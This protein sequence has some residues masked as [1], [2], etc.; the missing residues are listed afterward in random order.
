MALNQTQDLAEQ[1]S[2]NN[3]T[4]PSLQSYVNHLTRHHK[5]AHKEALASFEGGKHG[6]LHVVYLTLRIKNEEFGFFNIFNATAKGLCICSVPGN[7]LR[8][9][10]KKMLKFLGLESQG[11]ELTSSQG[12]TRA[13][14]YNTR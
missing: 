5:H 7:A 3:S 2:D 1:Y 10:G 11:R 4:R 8:V 14:S 12:D 6:K 9:A 13:T